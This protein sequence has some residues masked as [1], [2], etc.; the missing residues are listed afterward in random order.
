MDRGE[1]AALDTLQHGLA[2]DAERA[3]C[4]AHRQEV[5]P[6]V[7]VEAIL[8]VLGEADTPRG[9][10]CQLLAGNNA[11]IEQAMD[12]RWCDAKHSGGLLDRQWFALRRT[13]HRLEAGNTPVAA[14]VADA[15]GSEAM[16][17]CCGAPLPIEDAGNYIIGVMSREP[18]Q[19]RDRVLVGADGGRPR[20]R[21]SE[22][23]LVERAALPA[24]REMG[25]RLVAIDSDHDVFNKGAQQLLPV[26]R[27]GRLGVPDDGQ[28][29]SEREE[30]IALGL[31]NHPRPLSFAALQLSLG[32]LK[33]TQAFLPVA[34]E[35]A[36]HQPVIGVD[37][38][39][40][41]LGVLR[42]VIGSLDPEPPLLQRDFAIDFEPLSGGKGGGKPGRL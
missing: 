12:G 22:V 31:R 25:G 29:G 3:H 32:R 6:G 38:A 42:F 5:L 26:A 8:E 24:Q 34:F 30:T 17:V 40:A 20:A 18:A 37:G 1:F 41:A 15:A 21:Q 36:R 23:D 16:T 19:Q 9:A 2:R 33:R 4:L 7:T 13:G 35:A 39:I 10:R 27:R 11:V 14:Q 28:I